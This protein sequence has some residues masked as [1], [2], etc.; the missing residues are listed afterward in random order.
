MK[1]T[2]YKLNYILLILLIVLFFFNCSN[3]NNRLWDPLLGIKIND[4]ETIWKSKVDSL[5]KLGILTDQNVLDEEFT[6]RKFRDELVYRH[7]ITNGQDSIQSDVYF[8][9]DGYQFGEI[10]SIKYDL[11]SDSIYSY[12]KTKHYARN[13]GPI[14]VTELNKLKDWVIDYYN[15]PTDTFGIFKLSNKTLETDSLFSNNSIRKRLKAISANKKFQEEHSAENEFLQKYGLQKNIGSLV[16]EKD[17]YTI[18]LHGLLEDSI[19]DNDSLIEEYENAF[20]LFRSK[21]LTSDLKQISDSLKQFLKPNEIIKI[22]ISGPYWKELNP[23]INDYDTEMIIRIE[24]PIVVAREISKN[25][26]N[27][28]I[29]IIIEDIF[30][31]ELFRIENIKAKLNP[32]INYQS[33]GIIE[34]FSSN[35][36]VHTTKYNK[37]NHKSILF[38]EARNSKQ[39][40]KSTYIVDAIVFN[41]G[42]VL[43]NN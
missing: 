28:Q 15:E 25:I 9:V 38:E 27:I 40:L 32:S 39:G 21:T 24:K 22:D 10:R 36:F 35:D 16:W 14:P 33:G 8:N 5:V 42:T 6:G 30:E 26:S 34:T 3:K 13:S 7:F 31:D 17:N 43:K 37:Q 12:Y 23:N 41:D 11:G 2:D 19:K 4:S 29:T 1:Y 20:L 18:E